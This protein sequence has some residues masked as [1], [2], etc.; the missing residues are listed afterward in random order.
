MSQRPRRDKKKA[1][2][3]AVG[4]SVL[5]HL[6]LLAIF[7]PPQFAK[8]T[9]PKPD[10]N[11]EFEVTTTLEEVETPEPSEQAQAEP[12]KKVRTKPEKQ[13]EPDKAKKPDEK[14]PK[15]IDIQIDR[16]VVQQQT[17][18][19]LPDKA[20]YLSQQAN[21][22][23]E[24]TRARETTDKNVLPGKEVPEKLEE[25]T[26][27]NEKE[28]KAKELASRAEPT[29]KP[30]RHQ[31]TRKKTSAPLPTEQSAPS[32]KKEAEA[33]EGLTQARK[34]ASKSPVIRK[35]R[36][37]VSPQQLF[38]PSAKDYDQVF[39]DT[40]KKL[41]GKLDRHKKGRRLL[42]GWKKRER[43]VRASLEN[44]ITEVKPGN[45]TGVN[46]APAVYA[47]Y[48]GRIHRKI[49]ALWGASYLP[50]LDTQYPRGHPLNNPDL[51]CK[52]EYVIDAH[53]GKVDEVNIVES[54]G[55][56]MFDAEAVSI[57]WMVGPHPSPPGEIVSPDGKV[58]IHWTFWRDQRQCGPFGASIFIVNNMKDRGGGDG[59]VKVQGGGRSSE[60]EGRSAE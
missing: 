4:L 8:W 42:K 6:V 39:G 15:K 30:K 13:I 33:E 3:V 22:V 31:P 46:A 38:Q 45:H 57:S 55:E 37:K 18:E 24:E 49:H 29:P 48:I 41:A 36:G 34:E 53:S 50:R 32:E 56:L 21:K 19:Q 12:E 9:R 51:E 17:N 35:Q 58:Y 52:L 54:S 47:N 25:V 20:K 60:N 27:A 7:L 23:E 16:K 59:G 10:E 5:A 40:D 2:W 11:Q 14:K 44:N 28:R 26:G 43:A 1:F